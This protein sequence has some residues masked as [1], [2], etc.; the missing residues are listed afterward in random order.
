[1]FVRFHCIFQALT[2][3]E[4]VTGP[5]GTVIPQIYWSRPGRWTHVE[6]ITT[7]SPA[8]CFIPTRNS[9]SVSLK[10]RAFASGT[11]Q[12]G[13]LNG[14]YSLVGEER[15]LTSTLM[16]Y[17]FKSHFWNPEVLNF[18]NLFVPRTNSCP[19]GLHSGHLGSHIE[20]P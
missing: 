6:C 18:T 4:E 13:K 16:I 20:F 8:S 5:V 11:C 15:G 1:M 17:F 2:L 19:M 12:K 9:S 10:T 7:M 14:S 3:T